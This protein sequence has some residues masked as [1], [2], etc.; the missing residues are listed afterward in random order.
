ME[1]EGKS[2]FLQDPDLSDLND[3]AKSD[4]LGFDCSFIFFFSHC[5][6]KESQLAYLGGVS[7]LWS[8]VVISFFFFPLILKL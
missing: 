5:L 2:V 4:F 7:F 1:L 8:N 6:S 3:K